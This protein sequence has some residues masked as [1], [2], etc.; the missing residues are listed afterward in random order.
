MKQALQS[1]IFVCLLFLNL[2]I[3]AQTKVI[4]YQQLPNYNG[5]GNSGIYF[6]ASMTTS[7]ITVTFEGPADRWIALGFGSSMFTT[8]VLT[9]SN[10]KSGATHPLDWKDYYNTSTSVTGVNL[11]NT[12]NWNIVSTNTTSSGQRTVTAIRALSTGDSQDLA[13]TF[14]AT[15]LNIVWA[16][17]AGANYTLAYHGSTN[18]AYNI[19][20][21]WLSSPTASFVA[22]TQT[23]CAGSTVTF[24]NLSTGGGTTYNWQFEG[25]NPAV[26]SATNP[27]VTYTAPGTYSVVLTASNSV[28]TSTYSQLNYITVNPTVTPAAAISIISGNNPL[29]AGST[30]TFS[31]SALNGGSAPT[32]QWKLNG[33][34]VGSSSATYSSSSFSNSSVISCQLTSNMACSVPASTLS[35]GVTL[36]VNSTAA[37]S[38]SVNQYLGN[39]PMCV[40]AIAGFSAAPFQGGTNP[41]FQWKIN[42]INV[43]S[44]S[45]TYTTTSLSSGDVLTCELISNNSCTSNSLALSSSITL[46]VSTNLLP[47]LSL[48]TLPAGTT[49]C[50][51]QAANFTVSGTNGGNSPSYQWAVNGNTSGTNNSSF[52]TSSLINGDVLSCMMTSALTCANPQTVSVQMTVNVIPT[53]SQANIIVAGSA[54]V[55][56]GSTLALSSTSVNNNLWSTGSTASSIVVT[57]A[58]T[59]TLQ[60]I[61]NGCP[62]LPTTFA[63]SNFQL[64]NAAL[65]SVAPV[66]VDD[67]AV[68]LNGSPAG[69][70]YFGNGMVGNAFNPSLAGVGN[71]AVTYVSLQSF[72]SETCSDTASIQIVV[73]AC[74][75]INSYYSQNSKISLYPNPVKNKL[76]IIGVNKND[77]IQLLNVNGETC[78]IS[79]NFNSEICEA[80]VS[81][82]PEGAYLLVIQSSDGVEHVRLIKTN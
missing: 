3:N 70:N 4:P 47:T 56:P 28:G 51:G 7:S 25:A 77:K 64:T 69:G 60:Q 17:G 43:G 16:R 30:I 21:P 71:N 23:V 22:L 12:Q 19:S 76:N 65:D 67:Q 24:S 14:T 20:L 44:N 38:V 13:L 66:C 82:L 55:C 2:K 48:T 63:L 1:A 72:G 42:G 49:I 8:D 15:A 62:S 31:C 68:V 29:C 10:G 59:Y 32:F 36:T 26:S 5:S 73:D 78:R 58:G 79:F 27:V 37:A 41:A 50:S 53:P 75:G 6:S 40:G 39:N 11:D 61:I 45:P 81:D 18:R 34:N 35:S 74:T 57:N 54:T 46:T 80:D 33:V 52:S 9:Y